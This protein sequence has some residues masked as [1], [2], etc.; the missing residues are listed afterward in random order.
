MKVYFRYM[1]DSCDQWV[2]FREEDGPE[3]FDEHKSP[4]GEEAVTKTKEVP[5]DRVSIA[6]QPAT[7]IVDDVKGRSPTKTATTSSFQINREHSS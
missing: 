3:F 2:V 7:I 5:A 6:L 1:T 4:S